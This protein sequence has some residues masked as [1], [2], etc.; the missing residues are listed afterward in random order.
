M[1]R[2]PR[3][4]VLVYPVGSE[5][6]ETFLEPGDTL[7][8]LQQLVGGYIEPVDVEEY[9]SVYVNE[10]GLLLD[11]P[12]NRRV[13]RGTLHGPMV[14]SRIDR[15]GETVSITDEDVERYRNAFP[16]VQ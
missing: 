14:L 15:E 10:E 6:Y 13:G 7:K 9:L 8:G 5:P 16:R 11:L 12:A 4:R 2:K 1:P 3:I